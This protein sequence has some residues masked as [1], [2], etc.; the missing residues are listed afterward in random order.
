M[1]HPHVFL[2]KSSQAVRS[3]LC[4]THLIVRSITGIDINTLMCPCRGRHN[5]APLHAR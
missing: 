4:T 1:A 3:A 2:T 5:S